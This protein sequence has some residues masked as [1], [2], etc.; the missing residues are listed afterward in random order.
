MLKQYLTLGFAFVMAICTATTSFAQSNTNIRI[1][2]EAAHGGKDP[3]SKVGSVQEKDLM[4]D[5]AKTL[6]EL[7][8]SMGV[9]VVLARAN[10]EQVSMNERANIAG[11]NKADVY[12]ILHANIDANTQTHGTEIFTGKNNRTMDNRIL[13]KFVGAELY[14]FGKLTVNGVN[15]NESHAKSLDNILVPA[16]LINIG[17]MSNN[18][19]L[20]L[21]QN[22]ENRIQWCKQ[23]L[24]GLIQYQQYQQSAH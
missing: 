20:T 5:Y 6:A 24:K 18:N 12:V 16:T 14:N 15:I 19:D 17:Y 22:K 8:S 4:L 21:M 9:E 13:G 23:L 2:V 10:D 11:K 7:G 3:G 1:V